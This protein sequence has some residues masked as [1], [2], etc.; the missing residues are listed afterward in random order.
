MWKIVRVAG[1]DAAEFLN[2]VT[3][4]PI[5]SVPVGQGVAGALLAG[6][7]KVIAQ[8]DLL[9]K[10]ETDFWLC[11][12]AE[13]AGK[14]AE[15]LEALHF[16]ESLE[17]EILPDDYTVEKRGGG[18]REE[19]FPASEEWP[20]AVP[21]YVCRKG[22]GIPAGWEFARIGAGYPW[23]GKEWDE[24]T[25]ALEGGLLFAIDRFKGCYPGQEVVELSLN[26]GHPVRVLRAFE[27]DRALAS[28]EKIS[29]E[30]KGEGTVC[31][32]AG[33]NGRFRA[34]VRLPWAF[35]DSV[36]GGFQAIPH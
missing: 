20:S 15:S 22:Q 9:R 7:S 27:G 35:R 11:A 4:G 32:S 23:P 13:C 10:A 31:S 28:G 30:P 16:S 36:P 34:F 6:N 8:F 2:R 18:K 14:L 12:P 33:E 21:D 3:A 24:S 1:K 26:V 29:L 5:R 19:R 25:P 17:I